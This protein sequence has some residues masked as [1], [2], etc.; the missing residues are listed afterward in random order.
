MR[1]EAEQRPNTANDTP[2]DVVRAPIATARKDPGLTAFVLGMGLLAV[3]GLSI[4]LVAGGLWWI[5]REIIVLG[6]K[7][8]G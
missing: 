2:V 4:V 8:F 7:V 6:Q 3:A 5:V 1:Y